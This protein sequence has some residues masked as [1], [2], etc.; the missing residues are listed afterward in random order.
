MENAGKNFAITL[1]VRKR[2]L[3]Y[4]ILVFPEC[5]RELRS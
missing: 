3:I 2:W 5:I 4:K 1:T